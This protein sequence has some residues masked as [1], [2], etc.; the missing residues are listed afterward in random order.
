MKSVNLLHTE[1]FVWISLV[2]NQDRFFSYKEWILET[3]YSLTRQYAFNIHSCRSKLLLGHKKDCSSVGSKSKR[4]MILDTTFFPTQSIKESPWRIWFEITRSTF[5]LHT[6]TTQYGKIARK[7]VFCI[8]IKN[9]VTI[10]TSIEQFS[11]S[12]V[13]Y[14]CSCSFKVS[15]VRFLNK[16]WQIWVAQDAQCL[17][18]A[19]QCS[20]MPGNARQCSAMLGNAR[21]CPAIPGNSRQCLA[22]LGNTR[23]CSEM[24]GI[25]HQCSAMFNQVLQRDS[26][27]TILINWPA[28]MLQELLKTLE[29]S[30][31]FSK[32]Q[33]ESKRIK[34]FLKN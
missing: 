22:M 21:Q 18:N 24:L 5:I 25:A 19:Q 10:S 23:K 9:L 32:V 27:K 16:I 15:L 4:N 31:R 26:Q 20:T 28:K 3:G 14:I 29:D 1:C 7:S 34:R 11:I 30:K 6:Y 17:S 13:F 2:E 8:E 12:K 33:K